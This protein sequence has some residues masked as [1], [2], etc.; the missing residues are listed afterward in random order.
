MSN[1]KN[2]LGTEKNRSAKRNS[3]LEF[4]KNLRRIR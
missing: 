3:Q 2:P 1:K 4:L